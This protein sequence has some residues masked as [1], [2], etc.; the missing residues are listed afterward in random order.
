MKYK[1]KKINQLPEHIQGNCYVITVDGHTMFPDDVAKR[2]NDLEVALLKAT[3]NKSANSNYMG[4]SS[5]NRS[6]DFM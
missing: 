4:A 3:E 6:T 1:F 5:P 2:L